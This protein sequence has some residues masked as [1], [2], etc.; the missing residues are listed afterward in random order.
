MKTNRYLADDTW[1]ERRN[2]LAAS[3]LM[4]E[5]AALLAGEK[6]EHPE[7]IEAALEAATVKLADAGVM[8]ESTR[9]DEA[10]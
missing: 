3:L 5:G 8:P 9:A 1:E 6:I 4:Q 10:A 7:M 2:L